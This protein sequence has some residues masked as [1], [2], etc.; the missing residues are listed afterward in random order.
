MVLRRHIDLSV[1]RS[2]A[3]CFTTMRYINRLLLTYLLISSHDWRRRPG[4][5]LARY[6]RPGSTGLEQFTS[7]QWSRT[8][9]RG[10]VVAATHRPRRLR[11]VDD[12]TV[13]IEVVLIEIAPIDNEVLVTIPEI[14]LY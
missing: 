14:V 1:G 12:D 10:H 4:R 2:S 3:H 13:P 8:I 6:N 9:C 11:D 7:G 5:P